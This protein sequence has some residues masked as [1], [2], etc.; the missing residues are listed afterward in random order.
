MTI[1]ANYRARGWLGLILG[2]RLWY[3][4]YP[5]AIDTK[6]KFLQQIDAVTKEIGDRGRGQ[7]KP[8]HHET[9]ADAAPSSSSAA[10][11]ALPSA[12]S[13]LATG[14]TG[15]P[16]QPPAV[17]LQSSD[18]VDPG[19]AAAMMVSVVTRLLEEAKLERHEAKLEGDRLRAQIPPPVEAISA[20]DLAG[21]QARCERIHKAG[22]LDD[23]GP[24]DGHSVLFLLPAFSRFLCSVLGLDV[25]LV[26][27]RL[28]AVGLIVGLFAVEDAVADF[29]DLK[30]TMVGQPI[31]VEM[32]RVASSAASSCGAFEVASML[33]RLVALSSVVAS[34]AAFARQLKRKWA[35]TPPVASMVTRGSAEEGTGLSMDQLVSFYLQQSKK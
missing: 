9:I 16:S 28:T 6:A 5:A 29:V 34:D 7:P 21:L 4:F 17:T 3:P 31:T 10:A 22:L 24:F 8:V 26:P 30:T 23:D 32:I 35:S 2:S 1:Q 27:S 11:T 33:H 12:Q 13:S 14:P 20:E 18:F 19:A 15:I 25:I